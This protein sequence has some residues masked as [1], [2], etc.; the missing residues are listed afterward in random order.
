[1]NALA[2]WEHK[3]AKKVGITWCDATRIC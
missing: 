3:A 1:V 2:E